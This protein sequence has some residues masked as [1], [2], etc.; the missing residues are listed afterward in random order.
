MKEEVIE[1]RK[2]LKKKLNPKRYE[3][4]LGVAYTSQAL[5]MRY[6]ED[7][8]KAQLGGLL[9]DCA[10]EF[11]HEE[12]YKRCL[13]EGISITKEEENNKVLL[14]AKYGS[15]LAEKKYGI[16]DEEILSAIRFHTTGK[17]EMTLLEK[18]VYLADYIEPDRDK[19]PNLFK[20]RKMAFIDI[21][22]AIY[23]TLHD[24]LDYLDG[25]VD[26]KSESLKAYQY[27]KKIHDEK[28]T[29]R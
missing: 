8:E 5:A 26:S 13:K 23:E 29:K 16:T 3:H 25:N 18:I 9:H 28:E 7:L 1:I 19:A 12:I 6:G 24:V 17:P 10:R 21:D 27:Y 14:H 15:F 22:E 20:I 2:K 11:E 4:T